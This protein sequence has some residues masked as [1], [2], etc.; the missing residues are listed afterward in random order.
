MLLS[1][2]HID[3][4]ERKDLGLFDTPYDYGSIMHY[5]ANAVAIDPSK[6]TI[7]SKTSTPVAGQ[8]KYMTRY[9]AQKINNMYRGICR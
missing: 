7:V 9:D 1:D 4:K 6:P 8:E 2:R 3:F 5:P